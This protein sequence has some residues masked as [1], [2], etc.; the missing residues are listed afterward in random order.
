VGD[1]E[2]VDPALV[3]AA[4]GGRTQDTP[5]E[6]LFAQSTAHRRFLSGREPASG[7]RLH[8]AALHR[9]DDA[10]LIDVTRVVLD[11]AHVQAEGG[12]THR[13]EPRGPNKP[14]SKMHV[15]SDANGLPV[16]VGVSA[17]NT[18]DQA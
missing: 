11:T 15:L 18:H 16:L 8:E 17:G 6:T 7:G 2:A 4:A 3:D 14:G 13:P 9:L 12:R 5:D 10:S 1:R